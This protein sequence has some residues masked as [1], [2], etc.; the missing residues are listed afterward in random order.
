MELHLYLDPVSQEVQTELNHLYQYEHRLA[1]IDKYQTTQTQELKKYDIAILGIGEERI[2]FNKGTAKAPDKVRAELY[3]LYKPSVKLNAIDLGNLK[4]GKTLKDTYIAVTEILAELIKLNILPIIIGG[5]QDLTYACYLAYEKLE[6][7]VNIVSID[8]RIDLGN[9]EDDFNSQSFLSKILFEKPKNL[10]NYS[11][12][13]Y[14]NYY[15]AQTDIDLMNRLFFDCYRLGQIKQDLKQIEPIMRDAD[16]VSIDIAAIKQSDAPAHAQPSINGFLSDEICQ[17]VRYAGIS[18]KV[19]IFGIYETNPDFD[20]NKQTVSLSAQIIW[21]FIQGF[22]YRKKDYPY[23]KI[24][25]YQKFIVD[26]DHSKQ[27]II[28]YKNPKTDRWWLEV[29]YPKQSKY[30]KSI[31]VACTYQDYQCA[32]N[33]DLPDRWWRTYHKIS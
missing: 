3:K 23:E 33:Q 22:Y 30:Q 7:I 2:S 18:D 1:S 5:S 14:Q 21:H 16:M 19:S 20:I 28:F 32:C 6:Q 10:F 24:E 29:P 8:A 9:A 27:K 25:N 11:V 13:G 17:I 31:I 12:L 15:V 26:L 4:N